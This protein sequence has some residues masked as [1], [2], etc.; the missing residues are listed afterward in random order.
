MPNA[1]NAARVRLVR[2]GEATHAQEAG[3][4]APNAA[5][6]S[7]TR[8]KMRAHKRTKRQELSSVQGRGNCIHVVPQRPV[9]SY[10]TLPLF[11]TDERETKAKY[12]HFMKADIYPILNLTLNTKY[13]LCAY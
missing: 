8:G 7:A 6:E 9:R 5:A 2:A 4:L 11:R 13:F 1:E 12:Y 3:V 10:G